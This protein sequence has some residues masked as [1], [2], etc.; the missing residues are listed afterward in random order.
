MVYTVAW[1]VA[2]VLPLLDRAHAIRL[3]RDLK[4]VCLLAPP[5]SSFERKLSIY[6]THCI[7]DMY[8]REESGRGSLY[9]R[10]SIYLWLSIV[11]LRSSAFSD[12]SQALRHCPVDVYPPRP[13]C[14]A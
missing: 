3:P 11:P 4:S 8:P 13:D 14:P 6:G 12:G 10:G 2:Y 5:V 9:N 1:C 7:I